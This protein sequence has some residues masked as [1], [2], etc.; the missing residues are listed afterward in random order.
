MVVD[1]YIRERNGN[2]EIRVPWLPDEIE[3]GSG[4]TTSATYDI[5]NRG[6]V[7][8]P[9]AS[10]LATVSWTSIFP[11]K[12]QSND[13]MLRGSWKDPK[14][15]HSILEDWKKNGTPLTI[16]V[17]G[18]PINLDVNL[19]DYNGKLVGGFGD[20]EYDLEF[21]EDRDITI[22]TTK[23][24]APKRPTVATSSYTIKKGDTLWSIAKRFLG[25]ATKWPTIYNANKDII[26]ST[27][28]KRWAA[29]GIK[30]DSQNG[31]WIFPGTVITIPGS[32]SS[33]ASNTKTG[34]NTAGGASGSNVTLSITNSGATQ[35][36]GSYTVYVN[37]KRARSGE[38]ADWTTTLKKGD[39]VKINPQQKPGCSVS[40]SSN[41]F[42]ITANKTVVI[43]WKK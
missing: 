19:K 35:Y 14:T 9:T 23:V 10:G 26:E 20:I 34:G 17:T 8:V 1:I 5:L 41:Q 38:A 4:G 28:K 12:Y 13:S 33:T 7:A 39:S 43:T 22:T 29:A 25:T 18:Y 11:G 3:Y 21:L 24:E 30:R 31:Y 6:E 42:T 36:R 27:A 40:I 2:R 37:G 32:G 15:Y 16:I